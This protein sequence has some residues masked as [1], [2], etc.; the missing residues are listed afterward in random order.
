MQSGTDG[1]IH[2]LN[3]EYFFRLL[4]ESRVGIT[5]SSTDLSLSFVDRFVAYITHVWSVLGTVSFVF[6]LAAF[7]ILAY[8]TV[9]MYQ[10]KEREEHER[11]S[12]IDMTEAEKE[13]DHSRWAHI[14]S[15]IES[16]Q[17]RDW[18]EAVSEADIMLEDLLIERRYAGD[19]TEERLA[20]ADPAT[21]K[22]L[23]E[24]REAHQLRI[25]MLNGGA[26][27]KLDDHTAYRTIKKYEAVLKEF[28]EI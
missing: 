15:L 28:G 12:K 6:S 26:H 27:F 18:H 1:P 23:Q 3:L 13:K 9:R 25:D 7:G 24:A 10:L 4:Y 11:W 20:K 5:G 14:Q 17:E 8:S 21:F 16:P 22:T 2:Y 19:S